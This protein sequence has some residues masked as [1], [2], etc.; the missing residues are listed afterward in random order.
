MTVE[1]FEFKPMVTH[2]K[3]RTGSVTKFLT[4]VHKRIPSCLIKTR[5]QQTLDRAATR[6]TPTQQPSRND[7]RVINDD[8]IIWFKKVSNITNTV[9]LN[10]SRHTT[11]AHQTG[12]IP[13]RLSFLSNKFVWQ[14]EVELRKIHKR[15]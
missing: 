9:M 5:E 11:Q 4:G 10:L 6:I 14:M 3:H 2:L 1:Y 15:V 8:E 12:R 7:T 13:Y